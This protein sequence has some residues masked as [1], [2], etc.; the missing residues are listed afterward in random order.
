MPGINGPDLAQ[1]M[2]QRRPQMRVLYMSGYPQRPGDT[3]GQ[4][5]PKT[6]FMQKPFT[7][8]ALVTT[9]RSCLTARPA[10]N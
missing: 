10:G 3:H 7:A 1:R 6:A 5:S 2:V 4:L 8:E 9:V